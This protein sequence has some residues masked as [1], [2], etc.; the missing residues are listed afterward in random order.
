MGLPDL[1]RGGVGGTMQGTS[2]LTDSQ[3]ET[4]FDMFDSFMFAVAGRNLF[5]NLPSCINYGHSNSDIQD[6][7]IVGGPGG[8]GE[9]E[10][11]P[12]PPAGPQR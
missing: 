5:Q 12:G 8:P 1:N 6:L 3:L 11:P 9:P 7:L 10:I 2:G 4:F